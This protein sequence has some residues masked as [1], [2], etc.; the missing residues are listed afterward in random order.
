MMRSSL[1]A[2]T[3]PARTSVARTEPVGIVLL[4]ARRRGP[5]ARDDLAVGGDR[6]EQAARAAGRV[7]EPI[8]A[9]RSTSRSGAGAGS[10]SRLE[11]AGELLD[12]RRHAVGELHEPLDADGGDAILADEPLEEP[13]GVGGRQPAQR[14]IWAYR[15][16]VV[17]AGLG[18]D[19]AHAG[20]RLARR[21]VR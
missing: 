6:L 17:L 12:R 3:R 8:A 1:P 4:R 15:R 7:A 5:G 18:D 2:M 20:A 21:A 14:S 11:P 9:T 13:V 19:D 16:H 10:L